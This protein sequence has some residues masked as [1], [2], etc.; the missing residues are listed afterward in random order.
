MKPGTEVLLEALCIDREVLVDVFVMFSRFEYPPGAES[1]GTTRSIFET[2]RSVQT[3]H[4]VELWIRPFW[5]GAEID[6]VISAR[7]VK[8]LRT[9]SLVAVIPS[10]CASVGLNR[11]SL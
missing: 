7:R 1:H 2:A 5:R 6:R 8:G 3:P 9:M 10:F 11:R 4:S